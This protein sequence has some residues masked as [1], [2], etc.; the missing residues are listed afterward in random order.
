MDSKR[1]LCSAVCVLLLNQVQQEG[2]G[3]CL[4]AYLY[5]QVGAGGGVL[6]AFLCLKSSYCY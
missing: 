5:V 2:F 1:R 4:V 6:Y 3:E